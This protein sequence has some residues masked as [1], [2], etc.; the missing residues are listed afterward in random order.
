MQS[1]LSLRTTPW[2]PSALRFSSSPYNAWCGTYGI[3]RHSV[4]TRTNS[5]NSASLNNDCICTGENP[6][7]Y[8]YPDRFDTIYLR[9]P[10][11]FRLPLYAH[12]RSQTPPVTYGI[13][14]STSGA[15][16]PSPEWVDN[17]SPTA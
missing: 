5:G 9:C 12:W 1:H 7:A 4:T 11:W 2:G 6:F 3:A 16:P 10:F 17:C 13:P 15:H 14:W 8:I